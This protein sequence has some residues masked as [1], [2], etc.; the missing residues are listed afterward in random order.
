MDRKAPGPGFEESSLTGQI[1][2]A[3]PSMADPRF[4]QSVIYICAHTPDGAMGIVL[5][6]PLAKPRFAELLGQ[7][8]VKPLPPAREIRLAKGG[9]VDDNRGFV[10]H[11]PDWMTEGSLEVDGAYVLTA[12]MDILKAIAEGGGPRDGF[13]ALGYTGWAAGQLD[14][15]IL[16]NSWLNAPADEQIIFD[17][18][19]ETKWQRA[20][21]KLRIDPAML[22][23]DAGRA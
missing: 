1:L 3:M 18:K 16:R 11:T 9:P 13:L 20:L 22:S 8:G 21:A 2:I 23:G 10:L 4:S 6:Q 15:E 12:N 7:L 17:A 5:N 19:H 14:A